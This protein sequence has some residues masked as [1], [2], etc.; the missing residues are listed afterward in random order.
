MHKDH[1]AQGRRSAHLESRRQRPQQLDANTQADERGHG[2]VL[3]RRR[4][5]DLDPAALVVGVNV[6]QRNDL[7]QQQQQQQQRWR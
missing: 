7:Q 4:E 1:T 3:D 5:Q 6:V 2:A